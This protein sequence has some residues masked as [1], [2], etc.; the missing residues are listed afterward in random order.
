MTL[1]VPI[2]ALS[3]E[4]PPDMISGMRESLY[5]IRGSNTLVIHSEEHRQ[6]KQNSRRCL[7]KLYDLLRN[8]AKNVVSQEA[9]A[10][11]P[12]SSDKQRYVPMLSFALSV[13]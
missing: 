3:K 13:A 6:Q 4:V 5:H 11:G 10:G 7:T 1:R 12:G 8:V 9:T 2:D